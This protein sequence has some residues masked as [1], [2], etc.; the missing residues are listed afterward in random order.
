[1]DDH[2]QDFEGVDLKQ[3]FLTGDSA[4]ANIAHL[5]ASEHMFESPKVI[6]MLSIQPFCGGEEQTEPNGDASGECG[7]FGL[8]VEGV[9]A[10]GMAS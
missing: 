3:C 8:D 9:F 10:Y 7:V 1:M 4:G 2:T 6:G 5:R